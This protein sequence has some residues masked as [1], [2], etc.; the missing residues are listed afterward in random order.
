[1]NIKQYLNNAR[2]PNESFEAYKIRRCS[3]NY[4]IKDLL[5]GIL[6]WNS[7]ECTIKN[8][9]FTCVGKTFKHANSTN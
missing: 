4:Y 1:M 3:A 8:G 6:S 9:I 5:A 2:N 7:V